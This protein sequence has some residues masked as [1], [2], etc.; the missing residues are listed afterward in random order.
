MP[1]NLI[2]VVVLLQYLLYFEIIIVIN[3]NYAIT[4]SMTAR[5]LY[6]AI[7]IVINCDYAITYIVIVQLE[8]IVLKPCLRAFPPIVL[9]AKSE[10]KCW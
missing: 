8:L 10:T 5:L 4:L 9:P 2:P 3:C 7:I 6:F 1:Y